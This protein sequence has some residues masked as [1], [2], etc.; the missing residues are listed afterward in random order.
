[1]LFNSYT[2]IFAFLPIVLIGFFQFGKIHRDFASSWLAAASIVFYGY[3]NPAYVG[4]LFA[5]IV[6]NYAFGMWIVKSTIQHSG[7]RKSYVFIFGISANLILLGYYKYTNF[8]ISS[9]NHLSEYQLSISEII[10]PLGIS[11]FTFTQIAFLV[12]T[13]QG[14]V[15]E[16]N[17]I[18]YILFV[19]YFPHLVAGPVLHHKDMMPQF[20]HR[21]TYLIN[22]QNIATGILLFTLGL[23]KKVFWA[24]SLAPYANGVFDGVKVGLSSGI[25]PTIYEAWAGALTYTLQIYFDFSGYTDMALGIALMFNIRLPIN[26]N[27]PYKATSIIEFWRRWHITLSVFLRDYLYIPLGGNRHGKLRRHLNLLTT[28]L[29]GGLWHGAGWTFLIWGGMHGLYLTANH[30]WRNFAGER[31]QNRLFTSIFSITGW[32]LTFIAVVSAWVMFRAENVAQG[33]ALLKA[34]YGIANRPILFNDVLHGQLLTIGNMSGRG[35]LLLLIPALFWVWLLPNS[36]KLKFISTNKLLT[37]IQAVA[38][39]AFLFVAINQFGNYSPFLYF[40]F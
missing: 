28:M 7:K 4:L 8:F 22:W 39:I 24:D 5:S 1:M 3:W 20:A 10:L 18:H 15:K 34:M 32:A 2:F 37:T 30:L 26:F 35:L 11:F 25:I 29:L 19:T 38:V 31:L 23:C 40:Q 21:A 14:K 6:T 17:F 33:T 9:F 27:S 13:Y 36:S 12:D 16:Y